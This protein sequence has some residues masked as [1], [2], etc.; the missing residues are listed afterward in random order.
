VGLVS[1]ARVAGLQN[2]QYYRCVPSSHNRLA[3]RCRRGA[4]SLLFLTQVFSG[5]GVGAGY[6]PRLGD[7]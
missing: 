3:G 6:G 5:R 1:Q 2:G 7:E 4:D